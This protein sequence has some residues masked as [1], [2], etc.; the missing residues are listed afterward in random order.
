MDADDLARF[1]NTAY[2]AL[3]WFTIEHPLFG[4]VG[5]RRFSRHKP[6]SHWASTDA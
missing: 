6:S 2:A 5:A 4:F 3:V 1:E